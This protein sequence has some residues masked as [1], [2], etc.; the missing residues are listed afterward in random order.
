MKE[1]YYPLQKEDHTT[2]IKNAR[3]N[4]CIQDD[5]LS[6]YI[7]DTNNYVFREI[8]LLRNIYI[9][10]HII[11][12]F[13][14]NILN[15]NKLNNSKFELTNISR[16]NNF[17]KILSE[18]YF[19][20]F[21]YSKMYKNDKEML[22]FYI[23]CYNIYN[24]IIC[25]NNPK[26]YIT[27]YKNSDQNNFNLKNIPNKDCDN[28]IIINHSDYIFSHKPYFTFSRKIEINNKKNILFLFLN[29]LKFS[30]LYI[31]SNFN[32]KNNDTDYLRGLCNI[33]DK[34]SKLQ[35]VS[36]F[37]PCKDD[38]SYNLLYI[39]ILEDY[40]TNIIKLLEIILFSVSSIVSNLFNIITNL[41]KVII[42]KATIFMYYFALLNY[43]GANLFITY[44]CSNI[45]TKNKNSL[46]SIFCY[47]HNKTYFKNNCK[48]L[49]DSYN[50]DL[51]IFDKILLPFSDKISLPFSENFFNTS[52][53]IA[54]NLTK[55]IKKNY[56]YNF[57]FNILHFSNF[58]KYTESVN[59]NHSNKFDRCN[60][61]NKKK[62][63]INYISSK[64][65]N[66]VL[67]KNDCIQLLFLF[68]YYYNIL[69]KITI[70]SKTNIL[71]NLTCYDWNGRNN[72]NVISYISIYRFFLC[73][74]I[75]NKI[76]KYLCMILKIL[77]AYNN[78]RLAIIECFENI[79]ISI[80][81]IK[82]CCICSCSYNNCTMRINVNLKSIIPI[83][84]I[85]KKIKILL[86]TILTI[87]NYVKV[88]M[89]IHFCNYFINYSR[90]FVSFL[91][92]F[93]FLYEDIIIYIFKYISI[94]K[95]KINSQKININAYNNNIYKHIRYN[96]DQIYIFDNM[97]LFYPFVN[98]LIIILFFLL[99]NKLNEEKNKIIITNTMLNYL[100]FIYSHFNQNINYVNN[101]FRN[102]IK[103]ILFYFY[104]KFFNI[105]NIKNEDK[106]KKIT[107][108][109]CAIILK[110]YFIYIKL[111]YFF[112]VIIYLFLSSFVLYTLIL[113]LIKTNLNKY[114]LH[115]YFYIYVYIFPN[116]DKIEN[117]D[118]KKKKISF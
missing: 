61:W 19:L 2:Y 24:N 98:N 108:L 101:S 71:E 60:S 11:L 117:N 73:A 21:N 116:E 89:M 15:I 31:S 92:L 45:K 28:N 88:N 48:A 95:N 64:Y 13:L 34:Y 26:S 77:N 74:Y 86:I 41:L 96:T 102:E 22:N 4:G 110:N 78:M 37:Y 113:I 44:N 46:I 57:F 105:I 50:N 18:Y 94:H 54:N 25:I 109:G 82:Y 111:T 32:N 84:A 47:S 49:N 23:N 62:N 72:C 58:W 52:I 40:Q 103:N 7:K 59:K 80:S 104:H 68:F 56:L 51:Q 43:K 63:M 81:I 97:S 99:L 1:I 79:A 93:L 87:A 36:Q 85:F 55:L 42:I 10:K 107:Y 75:V 76:K 14:R 67:Q 100:H 20:I 38:K 114:P 8:Y 5:K 16:D 90:L 115:I 70:I 66:N 83:K 27:I 39:N 118:K 9:K 12:H 30:N 65:Y 17:K 106:I 69:N 33:L 6:D 29:K 53:L 91:F 3:I 35:N 112:C